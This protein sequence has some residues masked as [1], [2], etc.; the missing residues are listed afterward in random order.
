MSKQKP[1]DDKKAVTISARVTAAEFAE[2]EQRAA[3]DDRTVSYL[4]AKAVREWLARPEVRAR[5]PQR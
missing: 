1:A 2:L 3:D 4:V 5:K